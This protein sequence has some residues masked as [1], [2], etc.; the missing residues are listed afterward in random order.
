MSW[1]MWILNVA[2]LIVLMYIFYSLEKKWTSKAVLLAPIIIYVLVSLED[3]FGLI[4]LMTI[5]PGN[6]GMRVL[7]LLF[8]LVSVIFYVLYIFN[9][10]AES[11]LNKKKVYMK[12]LLIRISTAALTCVFFFTI[13]YTSIYKLFGHH[14]FDGENIG[15]D[16][17]SQLIS[18]L[19][20]SVA[21]FVTVGYGD[22][23]PV[24]STSRL[25]VIME[26]AFSFITVAYALSM[27]SVFRRI[28]SPG[29]DDKLPE[30]M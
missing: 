2:G 24:D 29:P 21:T 8:C 27:L 18:F 22:I 1:W 28:F 14:T 16:L 7:I 12:T 26:I 23:S 20:F 30:E 3:L 9:R 11:A 5:V 25:A 19:Y 6:G 17:L 13:I 4:D 15:N 10:I